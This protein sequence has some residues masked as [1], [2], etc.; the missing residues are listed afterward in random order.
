VLRHGLF[1]V[2]LAVFSASIC[3]AQDWAKKLFD[4]TEH[5]FGTCGKN[6]KAEFK[7]KFVNRYVEDLH[8]VDVSTSC[9]CT[10]PTIV[11]NKHDYKT[12][13]TGEI[14]AHFNTDR[15]TGDRHATLSVTIDK[16][17]RATVLL[18]IKGTIRSDIVFAPGSVD[19]GSVDLGTAASKT[20]TVTRFNRSDWK[21]LDVKS[22]NTNLEVEVLKKNIAASS[23]QTV[24]DLRVRLKPDAPA[25]YL[26]DPL[27]LITNDSKEQMPLDVQGVIVSELTAALQPLGTVGPGE[28][29]AP[30]LLIVRGKK[31]FKIVG[32]KAPEGFAVERPESDEAKTLFRLPVT[33][34]G[35]DKPGKVSQRIKIQ[36]DISKGAALEVNA[37]AEVVSSA[38]AEK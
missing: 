33:F 18:N 37:E 3:P 28:T 25:G 17:F 34:T 10:D 29:S 12:W 15:F 23:G 19:F 31:P 36:T 11:G 1:A 9:H 30:K 16:P 14:L 2:V 8:I 6:V 7:F 27:V 22:A 4:V 26:T 32:I 38:T 5:D 20:V 24:Y 21:I 35:T 13:E